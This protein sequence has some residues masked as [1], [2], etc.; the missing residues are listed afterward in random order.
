VL[1]LKETL[2]INNVNFVKVV[3]M[4]HVN[5]IMVVIT[6]S[7][8][9]NWDVLPLYLM[10][11]GPCI[12]DI[13]PSIS[14]KMQHYTVYFCEM[15]YMFQAVPTPIIRSSKLYIQHRAL[16]RPLLLPAAIV[17]ELEQLFHDSGRQ[18]YRFDKYPMLYIQF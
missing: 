12:A 10:F 7:E 5:I 4:M 6:V 2:W 3:A 8:G 13:F 14:K 11:M 15:L 16:V 1:I 18:Q 17:E 9:E